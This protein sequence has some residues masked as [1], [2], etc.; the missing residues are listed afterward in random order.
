MTKEQ[1]TN[2]TYGVYAD[3]LANKLES[4]LLGEPKLPGQ[5]EFRLGRDELESHTRKLSHAARV[6]RFM[7]TNFATMKELNRDVRPAMLAVALDEVRKGLSLVRAPLAGTRI[8]DELVPYL[9]EILGQCEPDFLSSC[10]LDL[11]R[12]SGSTDPQAETALM[13]SDARRNV[14]TLVRAWRVKHFDSVLGEADELLEF[15]HRQVADAVTI[16]FNIINPKLRNWLKLGV[17]ALEL[18]ADSLH[19]VAVPPPISVI[20]AVEAVHSFCEGGF[21]VWSG[22]EG[23]K[24]DLDAARRA[25]HEG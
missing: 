9:T 5:P 6:L 20:V 2:L 25:Q 12:D 13:A 22:Y 23:L 19:L 10:H 18:V 11:L 24:K 7:L 16:E 14:W 15:S 8:L 17:G 4:A 21:N 3:R 1:W